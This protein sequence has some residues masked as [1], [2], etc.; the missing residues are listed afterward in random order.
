MSWD[1]YALSLA[2]VGSLRSEDPYRKVGA[3]ALDYENR[4]LGVAYN[5]LK[6]GTV[7]SKEFWLDRD[8]RRPYMIHA[9]ANLLSLFKKGDCKTI[10]LTCSVI[11]MSQ[12]E[13]DTAGLDILSHYDIIYK[14]YDPDFVMSYINTPK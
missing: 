12:Y 8:K 5:G 9:E 3:C 13:K 14:K 4:V 1:V 11:Y 10:A 6:S 7:V 2:W